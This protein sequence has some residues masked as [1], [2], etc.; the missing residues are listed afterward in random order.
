M[1]ENFKQ[2]EDVTKFMEVMGQDLPLFPR[3]PTPKIQELRYNLI[4]EENEELKKAFE[5][6]DIIEVA[7]AGCDL[8]YVVLGLFKACGMSKELVVELFDEVQRSNMSKVCANQ[9]EA[10]KTIDL[11]TQNDGETPQEY[12]MK[13]VGEYWIVS[14]VSDNKVMKSINYSKPDLK[15]ILI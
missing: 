11:L 12:S 10:E 2:L 14:R 1:Q 7:D 3:I 8:L 15:S 4:K 9:E 13:E 5:D 6:G